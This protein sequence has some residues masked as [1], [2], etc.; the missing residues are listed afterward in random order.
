MRENPDGFAHDL[1]IL[2]APADLRSA[3]ALAAALSQHGVR[4]AWWPSDPPAAAVQAQSAQRSRWVCVLWSAASRGD[5]RLASEAGAA[6]ERLALVQV[7]LDL[8]E[9]PAGFGSV[10]VISLAGWQGDAG[11]TVFTDLVGAL[12]MLMGIEAGADL[13]SSRPVAPRSPG[14]LG[15]VGGLVGALW[16]GQPPAQ[17]LPE[18]VL[19][20]PKAPDADLF[21]RTVPLERELAAPPA[22]PPAPPVT[23]APGRATAAASGAHPD[24][25][26]QADEAASAP[27]PQA[28]ASGSAPAPLDDEAET[29]A[30]PLD[31]SATPVWLA[32]AAPRR[33]A[34]GQ[35]FTARLAAYAE[36]ARGAALA[37]LSAL[38]DEADRLLVDLAPDG[39]ARWRIGAPVSV[40]L[41]GG[42]LLH[43]EPAQ[44]DFEWNGMDKLAAFSVSVAPDAPQTRITLN[45]EVLLAGVPMAFVPLPLDLSD[46]AGAREPLHSSPPQKV[47]RSAFASYASR[48]AAEVTARLSTL[49]RWAPD[50]A[51]FQDCLDLTPGEDFK[52]QLAQQIAEREVF[53]LFWSR[54]AAASPWVQWELQTACSARGR[55][56]VL[57]MPL[58]DPSI[59]QP[60]PEFAT[61]HWRDRFMLAG[62]GLQHLQSQPDA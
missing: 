27:A 13:A 5:L 10:P 45:F 39:D 17:P 40:R 20:G 19:R 36:A 16:R 60:P 25:P 48:D 34:A 1:A 46:Q 51:I 37:K 44:R 28:P 38:G 22:P 26:R 58:E 8:G 54:R 14:L 59:A 52:P 56:A 4:L 41:S 24:V 35:Q 9:V 6:L 49:Q 18:A 29:S 55:E 33:V 7:Q 57:P 3:R 32:A 62:Y 47:P 15:R 50:L 12:S 30:A 42:P 43:I 23:A 31:S 21:E 11:E 2:S 61:A 53:L